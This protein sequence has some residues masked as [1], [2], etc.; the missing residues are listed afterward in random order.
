MD[1]RLRKYFAFWKMDKD[2][3]VAPHS[4]PNEQVTYINKGSV[5]VLMNGKEH[6]IKAGGVLV[7]PAGITHEFFCLEDGTE[8]LDFLVLCV[9]TG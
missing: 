2:A 9:K 5:K 8:D 7:I 1:I 6:I 3:H 4:H